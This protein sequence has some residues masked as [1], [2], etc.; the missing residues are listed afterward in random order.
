MLHIFPKYAILSPLEQGIRLHLL[1][2]LTGKGTFSDVERQLISLPSH[3]GGL[4]IRLFTTSDWS[5]SVTTFGAG[6]SFSS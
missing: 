2:S 4:G 5:P 3:L 6:P 1:P